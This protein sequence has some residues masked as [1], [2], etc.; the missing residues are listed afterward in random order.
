MGCFGFSLG[1]F[2]R[3]CYFIALNIMSR[4]RLVFT[5][6]LIVGVSGTFELAG[7][8]LV[9]ILANFVMFWTVLLFYSMIVN[10]PVAR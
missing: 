3:F 8:F 2:R 1:A 4:S 5:M 10:P 6:V 9:S 7:R